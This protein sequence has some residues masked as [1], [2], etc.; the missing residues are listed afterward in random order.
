MHLVQGA[1]LAL[2]TRF[3][4]EPCAWLALR[5]RFAF[6]LFAWLTLRT[7]F[8]FEPVVPQSPPRSFG[9]PQQFLC[10]RCRAPGWLCELG[11]RLSHVSC[12]GFHRGL[13]ICLGI[14]RGLVIYLGIYRGLDIC[15]GIHQGLVVCLS[16][17]RATRFRA[18][19]WLCERGSL[20]SPLFCLRVHRGLFCGSSLYRA[21]RYTALVRS[22]ELSPR[23][24][25]EYALAVVR[26]IV[27][28]SRSESVAATDIAN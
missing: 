17:S 13:V 19:G 15:L 1:W 24:C 21:H 22:H 8:A 16:S 26:L 11:S 7:R 12:L 27:A 28:S 6:E 20:L 9:L 3:A 4:F 23:K 18:P 14:H 10:T 25:T 5:T 2:R